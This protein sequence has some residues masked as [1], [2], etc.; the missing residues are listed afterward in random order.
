MHILYSLCN[1]NVNE[2]A[3]EYHR[4]FPISPHPSGKFIS[5]LMQRI[6]EKRSVHPAD[7]LGSASPY[8]ND[9]GIDIL[10]QFCSH[11]HSNVRTTTSES[12]TVPRIKVQKIRDT[13][14]VTLKT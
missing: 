11:P 14:N 12:N 7:G 9:E 1:F 10:A 13:I 6:R 3:R 5:Q 8:S 4:I 2:T